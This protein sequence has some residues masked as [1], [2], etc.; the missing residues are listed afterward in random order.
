M[1]ERQI[2]GE[3]K[4]ETEKGREGKTKVERERKR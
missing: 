2:E 3:K 1:R 4:S